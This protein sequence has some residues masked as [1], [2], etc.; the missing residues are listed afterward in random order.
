MSNIYAIMS[1]RVLCTIECT[2]KNIPDSKNY[3]ASDFC[4]STIYQ[5]SNEPGESLVEMSGPETSTNNS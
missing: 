2:I 1:T 4:L 5:S 3:N